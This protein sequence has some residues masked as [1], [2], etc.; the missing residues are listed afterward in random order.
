M[1]KSAKVLSIILLILILLSVSVFLVIAYMYRGVFPYNTY[2]NNKYCT[3]LD[4]AA[5]NEL[6]C[7]DAGIGDTVNISIG[8][9]KHSIAAESIDLSVDYTDKL[10]IILNSQSNGLW[11]ERFITG[12]AMYEVEPDIH[13]DEDKLKQEFDALRLDR[14]GA[15]F[16]VSLTLTDKDGYVLENNKP[17]QIDPGR[18]YPYVREAL[19]RGELSISIEDGYVEKPVYTGYEQQLID[20][21]K[22][23][24]ALDD[25]KIT[26][27]LD[28]NSTKISL[29]RLSK[30]EL[31]SMLELDNRGYPMLDDS[32]KLVFS[33]ESVKEGL[34]SILGPYNTYKNHI[35]TTHDGS[36]VH[37]KGGNF[38]STV[39]IDTESMELYE[40]LTGG[41]KQPYKKTLEMKGKSKGSGVIG[42]NY[43]E[44]SLDEQHLYYYENGALVLDSDV[45]TGN[46]AYGY[47]TPQGVYSVYFMQRNRTLVGE[48]YRSF[49]NY[50]I[51]FYNHYGVHDA[52]WRN[53]F[54]GDIYLHNGSHGCVNTPKENV[55][56]LYDMIEVGTPVI[57][58]SYDKTR[59]K[60]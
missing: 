12:P 42:D 40:Y 4:V 37:I 38:G 48:T 43:L 55:S 30:S 59:I 53:E 45:V 14:Q 26:Y 18:V 56:K 24:K 29:P 41:T 22:A 15:P 39:D 19:D 58:Y 20:I 47:D 33:E 6:L 10:D 27:W 35:F 11:V 49:V 28:N 7:K 44:V 50:W 25:V 9:E 2:I 54:G 21:D 46:H 13:F 16:G 17:Y 57:V 32:G 36:K 51:A 23:L 34:N 5:C 8:D 52:S 3:G 31:I 60:D 1:R